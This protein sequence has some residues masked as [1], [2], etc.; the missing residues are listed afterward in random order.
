M[1][2]EFRRMKSGVCSVCVTDDGDTFNAAL[3]RQQI[4]KSDTRRCKCP[5]LTRSYEAEIWTL[6][7]CSDALHIIHVQEVHFL[8]SVY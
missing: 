1:T 5:S 2:A 7:F 3:W 6:M 4:Y 8:S